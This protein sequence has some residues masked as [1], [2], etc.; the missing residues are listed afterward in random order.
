[1]TMSPGRCY[2][3]R[4]IV[5]L[6]SAGPTKQ[7]APLSVILHLVLDRGRA[8]VYNV[9]RMKWPRSCESR[10]RTRVNYICR[11]IQK[12]LGHASIKTTMDTYA[13]IVRHERHVVC[14]TERPSFSPAG[15]RYGSG[16][17]TGSGPRN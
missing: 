2:E 10:A 6:P 11:F 15:R 1:M 17:L 13:V 4:G 5:G 16:I 9:I 7:A 8:N 14:I 12:F 3:R